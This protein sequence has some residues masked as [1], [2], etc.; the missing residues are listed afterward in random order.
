MCIINAPETVETECKKTGCRQ[1]WKVINSANA[2]GIWGETSSLQT[3]HTGVNVPIDYE[4]YDEDANET[5]TPGEF[6]CFFTR[7]DARVYKKF[8]TAVYRRY[9]R[10]CSIKTLKIIKVYADCKD[11]VQIGSDRRSGLRVISVSKMEIKSL[12]HQR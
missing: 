5:M 12:K 4:I 3:F 11:I 1:L 10:T 2:I 6:H 7:Q 8:R 9:A